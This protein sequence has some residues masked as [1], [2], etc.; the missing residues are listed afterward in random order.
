MSPRARRLALLVVTSVAP[1]ASPNEVIDGPFRVEIADSGALMAGPTGGLATIDGHVYSLPPG[2]TEWVGYRYESSAGVTWGVATGREPDYMHRQPVRPL[3]L[4]STGDR[5]R[6]ICEVGVLRVTTDYWFHDDPDALIVTA[7]LENVG[8]ERLR[9]VFYTR[10]WRVR[11]GEG[12]T[13]PAEFPM[14]G[15]A[16]RD[17]GRVVWMLDDLMPGAQSQ[18]LYSYREASTP[19]LAGGGPVEVPLAFWTDPSFPSGLPVGCTNGV[20]F[21]DYDQ[22]GYID[23]LAAWSGN[24]WRNTGTGSWQL[25]ADIDSIIGAAYRY[26]AAFGDYDL[27]GYPDIATEPRT[28]TVPA[29]C[30][31]LLKNPA[32]GSV[33]FVDVAADPNI[34][35]ANACMVDAETN[36]W[37]DVDGDGELDLFVPCYPPWSITMGPGN[38]FYYNRGPTGPGGEHRFSERSAA[39]G[40]DNPPG[41]ARPEGA[42]F[43]DVDDDG[44]IDLYS[45]GT[46]YQNNST[47]GVPT[48]NA[49]PESHSGVLFSTVLE[50]GS[51][52]FDYDLDGDFDLLNSYCGPQGIRLFENKGDGTFFDAETS[53]IDSH[54]F[55]IALGVSAVDWDNDGD[56]DL[57][58]RSLFRRNQLVET[59]QRKFTLA[60]NNIS[61]SHVGSATPAWGDFD[62]DGDLDTAIGNWTLTGT[63]YENVL[64]DAATPDEDRRYVRVKPVRG[65]PG[66]SGGLEVEYGARVELFM[67]G[68]SLERRR[69]W[70]TASSAGYLTQNEYTQHFAVPADPF[71]GNPFL[72]VLFDAVVRFPTASSDGVLR[73]GPRDNPML[74]NINLAKVT[75][76]EIR[77]HRDGRVEYGGCSLAPSTPPATQRTEPPL[78]APTDVAPIPAPVATVTPGRFVGIEFDTLQATAPVRV[79]GV[80]IDGEVASPIDCGNGPFNLQVYDIT[81][82]GLPVFLE[83]T[84]VNVPLQPRNDR[85]LV[86]VDWLLPAGRIYRAFALQNTL[87]PSPFGAPPPGPI[88]FR[89]GVQLAELTPCLGV[90]IGSASVDT[91]NVYMALRY[92]AEPTPWIDLGNAKDG[93]VG[94]PVLAGTGELEPG[95][96]I[97]LQLSGAAPNTS[98]AMVFGIGP[99]CAPLLGGTLVPAPDLMITTP[100]TNASGE[101]TLNAPVPASLPGDINLYVQYLILDGAAP[102]GLAMSNALGI[103]N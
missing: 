92:R 26:G 62:K 93:S 7:T 14:L 25:V 72:D 32:D 12:N 81:Q 63:F 36:C 21:G 74:A 71:P 48:F 101:H 42:Q 17:V 59:G 56:I 98:F 99:L 82:G 64:Y 65:A 60:S 55:G 27:D 34:V 84:A 54:L 75:D 9:G 39:A 66:I 1:S 100:T 5:A 23:L 30:M 24:L 58:T 70:F 97:S 94:T 20:S 41:S 3:E 50:E 86:P 8:S 85:V 18:I 52:F 83:E 38:F 29:S 40:L 88:N 90:G 91:G 22:D 31:A 80:F 77:V 10:E 2:L 13:F 89:G 96:A 11:P 6:S 76:R 87:R 78:V 79:T 33:N 49:L 45:N 51:V 19:L 53:I 102:A 28:L 46:F 35:D 61:L 73:V 43:C 67:A 15:S 16:P 37:G 4:T 44:D 57:Q 103:S 69:A 68:E 95:G 47:P